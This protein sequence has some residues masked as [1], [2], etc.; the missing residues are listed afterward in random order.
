MRRRCHKC[1][2][3]IEACF[4]FVKSGDFLEALEGTR[5]WEDVRE[6]CGRCVLVVS[7]NLDGTPKPYE[8]FCARLEEIY[9]AA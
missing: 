7:L 8:E 9:A 6:L 4:G 1:K 3:C 5:A 2:V